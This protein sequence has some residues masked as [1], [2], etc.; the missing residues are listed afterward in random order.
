VPQARSTK[1][2]GPQKPVFFKG[3][4]EAKLEFPEGRGLKRK[5]LPLG[6]GVYGYMYFMD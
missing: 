1:G 4:Y 5:I 2:R 3:K 6:V